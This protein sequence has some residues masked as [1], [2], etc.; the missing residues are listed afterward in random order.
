MV[1]IA[2]ICMISQD[3]RFLLVLGGGGG[4][5]IPGR[6]GMVSRMAARFVKMNIGV[7]WGKWRDVGVCEEPSRLPNIIQTVVGESKVFSRDFCPGRGGERVLGDGRGYLGQG[8]GG[9]GLR[10]S[11][12]GPV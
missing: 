11:R 8:F 9:L 12:R 2:E 5:G 10:L 6:K 7:P 4:G 3:L 1:N